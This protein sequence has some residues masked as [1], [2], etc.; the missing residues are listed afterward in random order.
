MRASTSIGHVTFGLILARIVAVAAPLLGLVDSAIAATQIPSQPSGTKGADGGRPASSQVD[1]FQILE[2]GGEAFL[3]LFRDSVGETTIEK[4]RWN[5]TES[6]RASYLTFAEAMRHVV[7]GRKDVWD[8]ALQTLAAEGDVDRREAARNLFD[9]VERLPDI[10]PASL[11]GTK[12][13]ARTKIE[14]YELF[15]AGIESDWAYEA[16]GGAPDGRLVLE[17]RDGA[18]VFDTE[19]VL[20]AATLA[21]SMRA[22]PPRQRSMA[23]GDLFAS[24]VLPTFTTTTVFGW[25]QLVAG[26]LAAGLVAWGWL[27]L[28]RKSME[29]ARDADWP[30]AVSLLASTRVP[31]VTL[32]AVIGLMVGSASVHLEPTLSKLRWDSLLALIVVAGIWLAV[33]LFELMVVSALRSTGR[34]DDAYSRMMVTIVRRTVRIVA[35]LVIVVFVVQNL[36]AWNIT[37]LVGGVGL[38]ALA[39]SLAGK[40]AVENLFGAL[41]VFA[42]KPFLVGDWIEFE[43][44]LGVV[45]DVG[46]QVTLVRLATGA[47]WAVPNRLFVTSPVEN[48]STRSEIRRVMKVALV[49]GTPAGDVERAIEILEEILT[50]EDV[51]GDGQC[52]LEKHSPKVNF[53]AFQEDHLELRIDYWYQMHE[54][55]TV[56][57]RDSDR[58]WFDYLDHCSKVNKLLLERF[59]EAGIEFAFPTRTL[60]VEGDG[61]DRDRRDVLPASDGP[62]TDDQA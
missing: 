30:V 16:L 44:H 57:Q 23:R 14:R 20:G 58:G 42:N 40:N 21:R 36:F 6:P 4:P 61:V 48:L 1:L 38:L 15:P 56:V 18:W 32:L 62:A 31:A 54:S 29:R 47:L 17:L 28:V 39:V 27:R 8:R 3:D 19:T 34:E 5:S 53:T 37:A 25:L 9:V 22:I 12:A 24:T 46:H 11:P 33:S 13:V 7:H 52:D 10:S 50:S 26:L 60:H 43:G 59:G 49:Y 41:M 45:E 55:G 2:S 51:V 35:V